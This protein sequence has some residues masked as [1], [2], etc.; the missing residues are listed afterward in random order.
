MKV[1]GCI[2]VAGK[3]TK[4]E[5]VYNKEELKKALKKFKNIPIYNGYE[6]NERIGMATKIMFNGNK[7]IFKGKIEN[8]INIKEG[9]SIGP[10][11]KVNRLE[12]KDGIKI[13]K[14]IEFTSINYCGNLPMAL[15]EL[16][17]TKVTKE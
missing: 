15:D 2:L 12:E 1:E 16:K 3:P 9:D 10:T 14:D 8:K 13:V 5:N 6:S 11:L 4:N 17:I 7:L